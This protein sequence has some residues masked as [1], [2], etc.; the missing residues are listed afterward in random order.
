[1]ELEL[2]WKYKPQWNL[3][4]N[5]LNYIIIIKN[6]TLNKI[7]KEIT[8]KTTNNNVMHVEYPVLYIE[9]LLTLNTILNP[10]ETYTFSCVINGMAAFEI[11]E[12]D[13]ETLFCYELPDIEPEVPP[14]VP[15]VVPEV[16]PVVP[17]VPPVVPEVPTVPPVV[18]EVPPVVPE[19]PPV[20]SEV[21]PVVPEVPPVV[22]EVPPVVPEVPPVV[23][24]VPPVVPEVPPVV[25]EVPPVVPEV[26]PVV[27][28]LPPEVPP[29]VPEVPPVVPEVPPEVVPE[30]APASP[31]AVTQI[32][33][34]AFSPPMPRPEPISKKLIIKI[35]DEYNSQP[36]TISFIDYLRQYLQQENLDISGEQT[37]S[38]DF[39]ESKKWYSGQSI[40]FLQFRGSGT[41]ETN[42]NII[43]IS[44]YNPLLLIKTP[45]LLWGNIDIT[46]R[47][48]QDNYSRGILQVVIRSDNYYKQGYIVNI[49]FSGQVSFI[50]K[51]CTGNKTSYPVSIDNVPQDTWVDYKI[52]A[53]D[54]DFN[55][56]IK[57]ELYIY[58]KTYA[59]SES[60]WTKL[61][62]FIDHE[63]LSSNNK[64]CALSCGDIFK[65]S[66]NILLNFT[67]FH[68]SNIFLEKLTI[69]S[70]S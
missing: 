40:G 56:K 1:M 65:P 45:D 14:E 54:F 16:P 53:K 13:F 21:T 44:G 57:L 3:G 22:P 20:V 2:S 51:C 30:V 11:N 10:D 62:G 66:H 34:S 35:I 24:E 17:E 63:G 18:P 25:P 29:V 15:P 49:D 67:E 69:N 41:F 61:A 5:V 19:V 31:T 26:P 6:N 37:W 33:S 48:K 42:N 68:H 59:N 50:K 27:P 32:L 36:Q 43:K 4:K 58:T 52:I 38:A 39:S 12:Y 70:V 64:P 47:I 9:N 7:I 60:K 46:F 28:V 8:L 55:T 23:P